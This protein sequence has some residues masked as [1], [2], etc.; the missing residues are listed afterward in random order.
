MLAGSVKEIIDACM[1]SV[2]ERRNRYGYYRK[3]YYDGTEDGSRAK[4]NMIY[5]HV[6]TIASLIYSPSDLR[7]TI[8]PE[9]DETEEWSGPCDLAAAQLNRRF[10]TNKLSTQLGMATELSLWKGCAHMLLTWEPHRGLVPYVIHPDAFGV[11]REDRNELEDQDAFCH[12]YYVTPS[13]FWRMLQNYPD[14][15][16]TFKRA[17][18][19]GSAVTDSAGLGDSYLRELILG[20]G[21]AGGAPIPISGQPS[22]ATGNA[23][24]IGGPRPLLHSRVD[25]N[26]I[27]VTDLWAIDDAQDCWVM[28]RYIEPGIIATGT[29]HLYH[30]DAPTP[31][32]SK[33]PDRSRFTPPYTKVCPNE[34]PGYYWGLSEVQLVDEAQKVMNRRINNVDQ[35]FAKQ[36]NPP[37]SARG[38]ASI[39]EEKLLA[40]LAPGGRMTD[41]APSTATSIDTYSPS[42]PEN[43]LAYLAV[44]ADWFRDAGGTKNILTGEGEAGVRAG[45]HANTLLRTAA[46]RIRDRAFITE[47]NAAAFGSNAFEILRRKDGRTYKSRDGK[48]FILEQL[49]HDAVVSVDSHS[50]SPAFSG[51]LTNMAFALLRAGV[52]DGED[53]LELLP[54]LPRREELIRKLAKRQEEREKQSKELLATNPTLWEKVFGRSRK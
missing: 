34:L 42:M 23:P 10:E 22:G 12:S 1:C 36:A 16:E 9:L 17:M 8:E 49:P 3:L 11:L 28:V 24:M 44:I 30:P 27:C 14:R 45:V 54:S 38:S 43:A 31:D 5:S 13:E 46:G 37:R 6:D 39:T 25:R 35:I 26:L 33:K 41:S 4:H 15:E 47:G 20:A 53:A 18:A 40:L 29:S 2:A 51:D 32:P 48:E 21:P 19:S 52:I 7:F 50:S